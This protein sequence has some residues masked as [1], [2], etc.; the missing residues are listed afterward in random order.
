MQIGVSS[1]IIDAAMCSVD[2]SPMICFL[3]DM[4][5][6]FSSIGLNLH[7]I[8]MIS[9]NSSSLVSPRHLNI[10]AISL[11]SIVI[12]DE[13]ITSI[14]EPISLVHGLV[15]FAYSNPCI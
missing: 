7:V 3:D 13:A 11:A 8:S 2:F 10:G 4:L 5:D 6:V 1:S 14:D 15:P 12:S 9:I